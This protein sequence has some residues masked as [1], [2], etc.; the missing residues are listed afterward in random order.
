[1][2][3]TQKI[4]LSCI[5][6]FLLIELLAYRFIAGLLSESSDVAVMVGVCCLCVWILVNIVFINFIKNKFKKK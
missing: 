2:N 5:P 4:I 1:M 3:M 6:F